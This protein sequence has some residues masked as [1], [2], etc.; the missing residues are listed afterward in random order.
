MNE[1]WDNRTSCPVVFSKNIPK[2]EIS[3]YDT[4]RKNDLIDEFFS[5]IA[6][7][8]GQTPS[9]TSKKKED[10]NAA[11]HRLF[12]EEKTYRDPEL[13]RDK[14]LKRM[15]MG[16]EPFTKW[17]QNYFGAPFR[18]CVNR[19]RLKESVLLLEQSDLPI[20][21]IAA[22]VGF[23]TVRTF[24]RQFMEKYGKSPSEYRKMKQG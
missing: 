6:K 1:P 10:F 7:D 14:L 17:F 4:N 22:K 24:Q 19:L 8:I 21:K 13:T 2:M 3:G 12:V 20:E 16:K 18:E 5:E 9:F 15:E 23:G 11:M